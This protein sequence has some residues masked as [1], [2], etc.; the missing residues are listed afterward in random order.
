MSPSRQSSNAPVYRDVVSRAFRTAWNERRFWPLAFCAALLLSGGMYDVIWRAT[1]N[2][3]SQ[4]VILTAGGSRVAMIGA[5]FGSALRGKADL[6]NVANTFEIVLTMAI[7]LLA[8]AAFSC[9]AQGGLVYALGATQRG[10]KPTLQEAI[11][12]GAG[13]FWPIV[14]LNAL[15]ITSLWVIRFLISFALHLALAST[16]GANWLFYLVSYIVF[17]GVVFSISMVELFALNAMVLQGAPVAD[18]IVRGYVTFKKHW[19]VA[20][21]TTALLFVVALGIWA[22]FLCL[23]FILMVPLFAAVIA[24]SVLQ[25][26]GLLQATM[27]IGIAVFILGIFAATAFTTQFQYATWTYLYRRVGEGGVLPKLHRW[28]RALS[29][30]YTVPQS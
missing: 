18:A 12:V 11:H 4:G 13:A 3:T 27:G 7:L 15:V 16:T 14:A 9:I 5:A 22:V 23:Y 2:I 21:E 24:A 19:M 6:L 26:Q 1:Q 17:I 10:S 20:V 8:L 28:A 30:H 29:G 25:S